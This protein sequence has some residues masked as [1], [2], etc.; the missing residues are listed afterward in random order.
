MLRLA[1]ALAYYTTFSLAPVLIIA[2]TDASFLFL[3]STVQDRLFEE[4]QGVIGEYG[5]QLVQAMLTSKSLSND[6]FWATIVSIERWHSYIL[7]YRK[8]SQTVCSVG[9]QVDDKMPR[10]LSTS[11]M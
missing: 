3:L 7:L 5:A 9:R 10:I 1:T 2:I 11:L 8:L 4:M 6:S